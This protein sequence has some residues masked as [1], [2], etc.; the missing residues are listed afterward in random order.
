[1]VENLFWLGHSAFEIIGERVVYIDPWQIKK[2]SESANIILITHDHYDHCSPEDVRKIQTKDTVIVTV[3]QCK[4]KLSGE[5][6]TV[7]PNEKITVQGIE[8]NTLPAYNLN[9]PFHPKANGYLG[10]LVNL[11]NK[12]YYHAGDTDF[13]PEMEKVKC[14]IALLPVSGTY[15]M[16]AE[17]AAKAVEKINPA[18][19]IPMHYGSVAGSR[20]DAEQFK[21]LCKCPVEILEKYTL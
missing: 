8:I 18:L 2:D 16:T 20:K 9:K 19:A 13:I 4:T 11:N 7:K 15:V 14:E 17:E 1:M 6:I 21:K 5:I 10:F 12:I 3:S